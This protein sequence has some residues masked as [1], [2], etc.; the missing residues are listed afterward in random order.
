[1]NKER[2]ITKTQA[3]HR[4]KIYNEIPE[5]T[6]KLIHETK[7]ANRYGGHNGKKGD[8]FIV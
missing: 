5:Y 1:M 6:N 4:V 7:D 2:T 8:H 3:N